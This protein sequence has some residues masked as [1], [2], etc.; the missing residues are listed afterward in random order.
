MENHAAAMLPPACRNL[1]MRLLLAA[2]V[3]L[4]SGAGVASVPVV[5]ARRQLQKITCDSDDC[6]N[7]LQA[8]INSGADVELQPG[9]WVVTPIHLNNSHQTVTL[10]DGVHVQAKRGSFLSPTDCLFSIR[11]VVG[12][13]LVGAGATVSKLSMW[14]VDYRNASL[15]KRGEWRCGVNLCGSKAVTVANLTIA[16]TGGDGIYVGVD[17]IHSDSFETG[18]SDIILSGVVTDGAYRNGLS[19]ISGVNVL[20]EDCQFLRTGGTAPQAGASHAAKIKYKP[21]HPPCFVIQCCLS[22]SVACNQRY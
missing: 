21:R 20:V 13:S 16:D 18:C 6:T 12:V 15:Y 1:P 19:L 17:K 22:R 8:A 9:L 2:S 14:K 7:V 4:S 3:F 11:G 5:S 10:T